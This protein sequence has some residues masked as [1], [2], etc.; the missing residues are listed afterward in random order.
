MKLMVKN[1]RIWAFQLFELFFFIIQNFIILNF[2]KFLKDI[3]K[4]VKTSYTFNK[5][6][7]LL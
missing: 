2:T 1:L 6:K 5:K 3:K 4:F 7:T